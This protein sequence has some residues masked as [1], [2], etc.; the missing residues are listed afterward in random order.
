MV[1]SVLATS[2]IRDV[3]SGPLK[4]CILGKLHSDVWNT[5]SDFYAYLLLLNLRLNQESDDISHAI[6]SP[7]LTRLHEYCPDRQ[8]LPHAGLSGGETDGL[9]SQWM[10]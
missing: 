3:V 4:S 10:S 1:L 6:V 2:S 8:T 7:S 5:S 9:V